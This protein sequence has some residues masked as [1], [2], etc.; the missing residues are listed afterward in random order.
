MKVVLHFTNHGM[1]VEDSSYVSWKVV[2]RSFC[3]CATRI[4]RDPYFHVMVPRFVMEVHN[5]RCHH[6]CMMLLFKFFILCTSNTTLIYIANVMYILCRSTNVYF[7]NELIYIQ[8]QLLRNLLT[9]RTVY[10]FSFSIVVKH[11]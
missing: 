3:S 9:N 7:A 6:H 1:H 4:I 2:F 11:L 10:T 5:F 8:S